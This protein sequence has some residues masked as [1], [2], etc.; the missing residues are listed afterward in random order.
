MGCVCSGRLPVVPVGA[1][2]VVRL[3][4]SRNVRVKISRRSAVF[5]RYESG[6]ERGNVRGMGSQSAVVWDD[7]V[8]AY[9]HG[10]HHPMHPIRLDLTM[11]LARSLGV[12]DGVEIL[13]PSP[14]PDAELRRVHRADYLD[15]V[16]AAP[17]SQR[18]LAGY[19]L[20][21]EDNPIFDHMHDAAALVA[22]GSIRAAEHIVSGGGNRAI[23]I[24]G[25]LHHA[26]ADHASGFCVYNDCA[27]AIAW[28][29]AH[30]VE[31]IAYVDVDVHH[32]DGV[33][34]AFYGDPR[35]LTISLHQHPMTL[36]PGTGMPAEVGA[37]GADGTSVNIALPP[38]TDDAGWQRAFHAVVPSLLAAF[39][40]QVLVTQC[41]ADTHREDPLADLALSVDGQRAT[42]R[43]LRELSQ[44]YADGKWLAFGGGGY[45]LFRVVPRAW[46][47]LLATVLDRDLDPDTAIPDD[48]TEYAASLA[49]GITLPTSMTEH[50]DVA[51]RP[52]T[53]ETESPLDVSIR[54][55]RHAVFPLHGLDPADT[56]D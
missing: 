49:D 47:H 10:G 21:T 7:A 31:R 23:S 33:Q 18:S 29:L 35:V 14:A 22:G 27:V 9:D 44:R 25:G 36:F 20:G 53:G 38:K 17:T 37:A 6:P 56:R 30:G 34:A 16:R 5:Q 1:Q 54:A 11:R 45:A 15:A 39:R 48:W 40:P 46:T 13:T 3:G 26:M 32:G 43:S 41:G 2:V 8:L 55:S 19:G 28:M 12:L 24:S 4:S 51:F 52:W 42:Y 50:R